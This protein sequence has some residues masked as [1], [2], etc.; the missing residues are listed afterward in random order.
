M[1]PSDRVTWVV[2]R[3]AAAILLKAAT[4]VSAP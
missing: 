3:D 4:A 2:D 1:L